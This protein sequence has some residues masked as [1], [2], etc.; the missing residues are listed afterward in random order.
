MIGGPAMCGRISIADLSA[1]RLELLFGLGKTLPFPLSYNLAPPFKILAIRQ[2]NLSRTLALLQWGLIPHW[3]KDR[4]IAAHTFNARIETLSQKPSFRD[5]LKSK[6]CIIPVSGFYE[7]RQDGRRKKPF[8]IFREDRNPAALAGLWDCWVDRRS[9]VPIDSCTLISIP[10]THLMSEI[11]ERMPAI[12]EP[13]YFDVWL[14]P[15]F[16]ETHVLQDIL[17]AAAPKLE[18]YAVSGYVSNTRNDGEKCI[19]RVDN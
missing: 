7:W 10:A 6:R 15:Q 5:S 13:E 2:Q 18:T 12:L 4:A 11:H 19:E 16:K 9:G 1:D 3:A 8:Y 17:R 14:D